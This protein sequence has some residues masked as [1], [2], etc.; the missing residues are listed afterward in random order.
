MKKT[1]ILLVTTF[2]LWNCV[3][4]SQKNLNDFYNDYY[5]DKNR[6]T[7]ITTYN[8]IEG[9]PYLDD[10]FE[11]G[12]VYTKDQNSYNIP[13]RLNL[14]QDGF[15]FKSGDRELLIS[16]PEILVK[17]LLKGKEYVYYKLN[18]KNSFVEL[19][20]SGKSSLICK[21]T[22]I[23]NE[24]QLPAAYK[25]GKPAHFSRRKDLLYIINQENKAFLIKNRKTFYEV[26]NDRK[27]EISKYI[28][29]EKIS[30]KKQSDLKK[31][32]QYYNSL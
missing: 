10:N 19:I 20:V 22:V 31:L 13:L 8:D 12:I 30:Y 17:I 1:F 21:K 15:E 9:S 16:K 28:K 11:I 14:H 2:L 3:V 29:N 25:D 6:F 32:V 23:L 18:K 27:N 26:F 4:M 24:E 7:V 5:S